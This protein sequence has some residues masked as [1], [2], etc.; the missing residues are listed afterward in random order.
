MM[1]NGGEQGGGGLGN[2]GGELANS[3]ELGNVHDTVLASAE[4]VVH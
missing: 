1:E 3:P 2:S 4:S